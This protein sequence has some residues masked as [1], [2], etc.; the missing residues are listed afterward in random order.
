MKILIINKF[1][2]P[3][4][5][6]ETY[7]FK[8]GKQLQDMGHEVQFFGME[9]EGRCVGNRVESYTSDM[10]FHSGKLG[11][12][13]YPFKIIY[14]IEARKKLRVVL[15]DFLPDVV[16]VNNFNFQLT[17]SILYEIRDFEKKSEKK[18]K[19]I[20]TAHDSQLVCPNHLMQQFLTRERCTRCIGGSPWNCAKYK[21]IH[22]SFVKSLLGSVEAWIYRNLGT[23]GKIDT[24]ICPS[25]FLQEK[26]NTSRQLKD[27]TVVMHN[28]VDSIGAE[29]KEI[30][31]ENVAESY[32]AYVGRFSDEKGIGTLLKV[33]RALPDVPFIFA[34][35]GPLADEVNEVPNVI[36][37]G[38]L[39]G[40]ELRK[41]MGNARFVIFP[42]EC[43]ENCPFTVMEALSYGTPVIG[44]AIGGVSELIRDGENGLLFESGNAE[45][46]QKM[47][48]DLWQ[49][50]AQQGKLREGC[51]KEKFDD[52]DMYCEKLLELYKS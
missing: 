45:Q 25:K 27:K 44:G 16:H 26:L 15:K 14:S 34:G 4:G 40:E 21:C 50:K 30:D 23:Y 19:I 33:C 3:N 52:L 42:S 20:Y 13:L 7:I 41:L 49:D 11:K 37:R 5:G 2:H 51:A 31:K 12:M 8:V 46:L 47:I 24:V 10:D 36:N 1:L 39:Q 35:S 28:F 48:A 17:P 6:S 38:F 9:H 43:N 32:V 22:G 29:A 18:I